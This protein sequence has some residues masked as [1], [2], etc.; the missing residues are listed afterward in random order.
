MEKIFRP[1]HIVETEGLSEKDAIW[2]ILKE[3]GWEEVKV[4]EMLK[5]IEGNEK[6]KLRKMG[7]ECQDSYPVTVTNKNGNQSRGTVFEYK[8]IYPIEDRPKSPFSIRDSC[9]NM[10][11]L[12]KDIH[13]ILVANN[14]SQERIQATF[15][16][17]D[18]LIELLVETKHQIGWKPAYNSFHG[19]H[20]DYEIKPM[21]VEPKKRKR[22]FY[23]SS[24]DGFMGDGGFDEDYM[25]DYNP[26]GDESYDDPHSARPTSWSCNV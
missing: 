16:N 20:W 18:A 23:P 17:F 14:I 19:L 11:K 13:E 22:R 24:N 26:M 7:F 21:A 10:D 9:T 12:I 15:Q 25:D 5:E 8:K 4:R 1:I 6:E 2:F 3:E